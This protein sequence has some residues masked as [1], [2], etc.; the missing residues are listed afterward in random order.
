M[1]I[2]MAGSEMAPLARTG[3]LGDVIQSLPVELTKLG[4]EVSMILPYYRSLRENKALKPKNTGV[5]FSVPLGDRWVEAEVLEAVAPN[6]VQLFLVQH[7][8]FFDRSGLYGT[9][10]RDYEDNAAR[11]IFFSKAVLE[12]AGRLTPAPDLIHVHDWQTALIPVLVKDRSLPFKTVLTIHN[13]AYQ[14]SFWGV[15]FGLTNLPSRYYDSLE[16]FGNINLLKAGIQFADAITTVSERYA[17]EIQTAEFGCGLDGV[18]RSN[19]YKLTGILNGADSTHWNPATDKLIP[20]KF[21]AENLT[22]K[23]HCRT[24]LLSELGL[25]PKPRG[26]VFGM[27]TRL[28]E[29]KGIDILLPLL[30]RLLSDDV[31]LVILG[32]GESAYE[33]EL[34]IAC[35]KHAGR[36]AFR[37]DWDEKLAHL[38]TAGSDISLIPSHFEPCGLVAMYSLRYGAIPIAHACG[39]LYQ[40]IQDSDPT[41]GNGNG[42]LFFDYSPEAFW[43]SIGRARRTFANSVAWLELM[44]HAMNTDFSWERAAK[45]YEQ[46][47][48]KICPPKPAKAKATATAA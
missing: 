23:K 21:S 27:V 11:F 18:V 14:G 40:M 26:P 24:K 25:D 17:R 20:R 41:T 30:D 7:E 45:E 5:R 29:Q 2:L 12:L 10:G 37:R 19:A 35:K 43:D 4:H 48:R 39:G 34:M 8:E 32:E 47:Y 46:I 22:G 13:L 31:R 36:F 33:R 3:G 28:A 38:I 6:G 42:F 9:D 1:K 16:F 15:D 44:Q